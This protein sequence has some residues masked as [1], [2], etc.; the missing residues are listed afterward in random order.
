MQKIE[1]LLDAEKQVFFNNLKKSHNEL[2]V[3]LIK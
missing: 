2:V 1:L 3:P